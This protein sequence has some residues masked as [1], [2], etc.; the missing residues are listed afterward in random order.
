MDTLDFTAIHPLCTVTHRF[1][2][3]AEAVRARKAAI[4]DGARVSYLMVSPGG[5]SHEFVVA[6]PRS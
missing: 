3:R 6:A 1:A 4:A 2:T 5:R